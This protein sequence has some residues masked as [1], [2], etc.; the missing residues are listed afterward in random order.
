MYI[1]NMEIQKNGL[2]KIILIMFEYKNLI[3]YRKYVY[4]IC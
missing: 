3:K 2:F 1:M 4:N